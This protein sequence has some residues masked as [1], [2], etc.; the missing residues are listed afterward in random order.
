M[1]SSVHCIAH[2]DIYEELEL[3]EIE[4]KKLRDTISILVSEVSKLKAES[5]LDT[6]IELC[7]V[8]NVTKSYYKDCV[9]LKQFINNCLVH[10]SWDERHKMTCKG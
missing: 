4:N 7:A 10:P 5:S 2:V 1:K 9:T 3:L 6:Y 8:Y